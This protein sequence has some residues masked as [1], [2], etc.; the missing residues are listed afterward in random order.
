MKKLPC[1]G[2]AFLCR[3]DLLDAADAAIFKPDF[4]AMRMKA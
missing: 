3:N 4:N 1:S 2:A